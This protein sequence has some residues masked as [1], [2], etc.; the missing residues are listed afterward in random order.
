VFLGDDLTTKII[1]QGKVR[2]ILQDGRKRT[3]LGVL[4]ILGLTR[5]LISISNISDVGVHTLFQKDSHKMVRGVMVSMK[6]V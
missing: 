1:G 2:L 4:H 6:G 5:N 3:L